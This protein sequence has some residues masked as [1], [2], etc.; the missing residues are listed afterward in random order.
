MSSGPAA[1]KCHSRRCDKEVHNLCAQ[2]VMGDRFEP[3]YLYCSVNCY[4]IHESA[5]EA[6]PTSLASVPSSSSASTGGAPSSSA[7]IH[8]VAKSRTGGKKSARLPPTAK[9]P[10][11]SPSPIMNAFANGSARRTGS[12]SAGEGPMLFDEVVSPSAR[13]AVVAS[14]AP[15][16]GSVTPAGQGGNLGMAEGDE[17]SDGGTAGAGSSTQTMK[18]RKRQIVASVS[19]REKVKRWMRVQLSV[20]STKIA[21]KALLEFTDVFRF[22]DHVG[23]LSCMKKAQ[24]YL[25]DAKKS[26]TEAES[27]EIANARAEA[28]PRGKKEKL[29]ATRR[30]S[31]IVKRGYVKA[32]YGRGRKRQQWVVDLYEELVQDFSHARN[33]G[34]KMNNSVIRAM[35]LRL[36]RDAPE[37]CSFHRLERDSRSGRPITEH[38]DIPF[39]KRFCQTKDIVQRS[40]AGKLMCSPKKRE[41]IDRAVVTHLAEL[42]FKFDTGEYDED[43][44][45]NIDETALKVDMDNGRTMDF[46]G[47][48]HVSYMDTVS[49]SEGFT[50][51]MNVGG[52]RRGTIEPGFVVFKNADCNYPIRNVPDNVPGVSYRTGRKAWMDQRVF[53]EMLKERKFLKPMPGGKTRILFMDNVGSHNLSPEVIKELERIKTIARFLPKNSTELTQACD[54]YV[55]SVFKQSWRS[56]WDSKKADDILRGLFRD[57]EGGSGKVENPGKHY[58]LKLTAQALHDARSK[59]DKDGFSFAR[60]SMMMCGLSLGPDGVWRVEQLR[61]ELRALVAKYRSLFDRVTAGLELQEEGS[62]A[63]SGD[64]DDGADNDRNE[65]DEGMGSDDDDEDVS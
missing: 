41:E 35:A 42:K 9:L 46:E 30:S 21:G 11:F 49:G 63:V 59:K 44:V 8:P 34:I 31:G 16:G 22:V 64:E 56:L 2:A 1:H 24:R 36:V 48:S 4:L 12:R 23:R 37:G 27:L 29:V 5:S 55:I 54:A 38:I 14:R 33:A 50:F 25:S 6:A 40:K 39:V 53:L 47:V 3:G 32:G 20:G 13:D 19:D 17:E 7:R 43:C 60:K 61:P 57:S 26:L 10:R 45:F 65:A 28:E 52:G 62:V 58:F 18:A 15:S 51:L